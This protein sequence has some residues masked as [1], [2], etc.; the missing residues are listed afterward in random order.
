MKAGFELDEMVAEKVLGWK[1]L[2]D[3]WLRPGEDESVELP[4][5]SRDISLAWE[6]ADHVCDDGFRLQ[7]EGSRLWMARF[8][9]SAAHTLETRANSA[10]AKSPAQAICLAALATKGVVFQN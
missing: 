1:R 6:V 2:S 5:F 10:T 9:K 3:R 8:Y 7:I 4:K